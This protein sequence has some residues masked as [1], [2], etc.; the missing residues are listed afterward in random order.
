[1]RIEKDEFLLFPDFV[2]QKALRNEYLPRF[3]QT[4]HQWKSLARRR[5][6][7]IG[8]RRMMLSLKIPYNIDME[9][10]FQT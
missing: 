2:L 9:M 5:G 6:D 4:F 10:S 1:M 7:G 3:L 8:E